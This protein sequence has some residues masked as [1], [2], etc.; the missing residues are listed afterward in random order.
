MNGITMT[1]TEVLNFAARRDAGELMCN[2]MSQTK[3]D[4]PKRVGVLKWNLHRYPDPPPVKY[5]YTVTPYA[6]P[7]KWVLL[8]TSRET[9][10]FGAATVGSRIPTGVSSITGFYGWPTPASIN[11]D[12]ETSVAMTALSARLASGITEILVSLVEADKTVLMLVRALKIVSKPL[13]TARQIL[14]FSRQDLRDP[15]KRK[16]VLDV[17]SDIWLEGR[18]GWRPAFYDIM[19]YAE[20]AKTSYNHRQTVRSTD[21]LYDAVG[22]PTLVRNCVLYGTLGCYVDY[23][24][25]YKAKVRYGQTADFT[26]SSESIGFIKNLGGLDPLG[27]VLELIPYSFV[28]EW[29]INLGDVL[30]AAT[31]YALID[32]RVGWATCEANLEVKVKSHPYSESWTSPGEERLYQLELLEGTELDFEYSEKAV[33]KF[34]NP[35]DSFLPSIGAGSGLNS[36]KLL[37]GIALLRKFLQR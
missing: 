3:Y 36:L 12:V 29:F 28:L 31:A 17:A 16:Q 5:K 14:R 8:G 34:R 22:N 30:Q 32:E 27:T 7:L 24:P 21:T 25:Y 33:H 26:I 37:D 10:P 9:W 13:T 11:G 23:T 20:L 35:V 4:F 2:Y 15:V 6:F 1:D 19:S 18:Y